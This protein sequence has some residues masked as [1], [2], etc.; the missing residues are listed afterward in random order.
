MELIIGLRVTG[1]NEWHLGGQEER[2][3]VLARSAD[4]DKQSH[5]LFGEARRHLRR[6]ER[7]RRRR[8]RRQRAEAAAAAVLGVVG[9][10]GVHQVDGGAP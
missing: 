5:Q 9:R 7:P 8:R 6:A 1:E 3:F 10:V 4:D 2:L